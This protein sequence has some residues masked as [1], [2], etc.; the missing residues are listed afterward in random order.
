M[1]PIYGRA[2]GFPPVLIHVGT[3]EIL[4]DEALAWSEKLKDVGATVQVHVGR[5]LWH[6]W[7]FFARLVPEANRALHQAG[8]WLRL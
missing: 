2:D 1:S 7:P 3:H 8:G 5:G 6:A 4:H